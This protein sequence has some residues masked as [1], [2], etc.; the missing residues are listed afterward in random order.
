MF[1]FVFELIWEGLGDE[2]QREEMSRDTE[3]E[4]V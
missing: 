3:N 4:I 1:W 2:K